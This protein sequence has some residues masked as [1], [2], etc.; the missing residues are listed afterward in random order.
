MYRVWGTEGSPC[1]F[2]L[3]DIWD[4]DDFD[5]RSNNFLYQATLES[6]YFPCRTAMDLGL[7]TEPHTYERAS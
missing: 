3:A 4:P 6:F 2:S 1:R 5:F 7:S